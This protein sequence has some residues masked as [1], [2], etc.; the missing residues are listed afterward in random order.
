MRPE[1]G[2]KFVVWRNIFL[3]KGGD[4]GKEWLAHHADG[5]LYPKEGNKKIMSRDTMVL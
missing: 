2:H 3:I 5:M 1:A 4:S